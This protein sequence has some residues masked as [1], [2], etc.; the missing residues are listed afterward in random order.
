[1]I[2]VNPQ[3]RDLWQRNYLRSVED[4]AAWVAR[5]LMPVGESAVI[6]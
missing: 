4:V 1:M 6:A 2:A 3:Y 5:N